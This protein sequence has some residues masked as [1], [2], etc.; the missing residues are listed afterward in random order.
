M[1]RES[2]GPR[3]WRLREGDAHPFPSSDWIEGEPIFE[4]GEWVMPVSEHENLRVD[5]EALCEEF[6]RLRSV[7]TEV[8]EAC[9]NGD[10]ALGDA[11]V[12]LGLVLAAAGQEDAND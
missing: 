10:D 6:K 7:A 4:D 8:F 3:R 5:F 9:G 2:S 12:T 1:P 11:L